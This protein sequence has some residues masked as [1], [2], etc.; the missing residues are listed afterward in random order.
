M[1]FHYQQQFL[2]GTRAFGKALLPVP[3]CSAAADVVDRWGKRTIGGPR[4]D[5]SQSVSQ[6]PADEIVTPDRERGADLEIATA[7]A[8]GFARLGIESFLE[9]T[10]LVLFSI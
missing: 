3:T 8:P 5:P 1:R 2:Q 6:S 10:C 9:K 4:T 7:P